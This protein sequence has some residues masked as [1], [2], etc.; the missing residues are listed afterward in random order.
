MQ[1]RIHVLIGDEDR[2][3][4]LDGEL[5]DPHVADSFGGNHSPDGFNWGYGGSGPAQLALC[6]MVTCTYASLNHQ[7]FKWKYIATLA[8]GKSFKIMFSDA[9][10]VALGD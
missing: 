9:D 5:L 10:L 2:N 1:N 6:V 8:Q 7:K 4:W 3:V